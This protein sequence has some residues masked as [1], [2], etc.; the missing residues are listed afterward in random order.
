MGV[1]LEA[2]CTGEDEM[3]WSKLVFSVVITIMLLLTSFGASVAQGDSPQFSGDEL[4]PVPVTPS[5]ATFTNLPKFTFTR[6]MNATNYAIEVWNLSTDPYSL[7]YTF[8][9]PGSCKPTTCTLKP[10]TKLAY[11]DYL[12]LKGNYGWRVRA[13]A[14]GSWQTTWSNYMSFGVFSPGFY[15]TFNTLP[16]KW[17]VLNGEWFLLQDAGYLKTKGALKVFSTMVYRDYFLHNRGFVYEVIMKRRNN[18]I[19]FNSLIVH[20]RPNEA[21]DGWYDEFKYEFMYNNNRDVIFIGM[22]TTPKPPL[23][24]VNSPWVKPNDW[25]KLTVW[26]H[27]TFATLWINEHYLGTFELG[28]AD[29]DIGGNVGFGMWKN[30]DEKSP[31]VVDMARAYYTN[32]PPYVVP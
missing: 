28:I 5:G 31:L 19:D 13:K 16:K 21:Q 12:L 17:Q 27:E 32:E 4:A 7:V 2:L 26:M 10:T 8:K 25:N 6:N 23:L 24:N 3:W 18:T 11:Y 1:E 22:V 14:G 20:G 29:I 30:V 15:T 9:G